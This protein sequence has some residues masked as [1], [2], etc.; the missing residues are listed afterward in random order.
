MPA[1]AFLLSFPLSV[2]ELYKRQVILAS[3]LRIVLTKRR[4]NMNDTGTVGQGNIAV[5]GNK[6]RFYAVFSH[7]FPGTVKQRLIFLI[8]G[9]FRIPLQYFVAGFPPPS[10]VSYQSSPYNRCNRPPSP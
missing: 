8:F 3:H 9:S 2:D 10:T 7:R 5:T 1:K 4:G 6:I